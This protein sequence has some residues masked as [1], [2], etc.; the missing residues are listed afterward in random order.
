MIGRHCR[1]ARAMAQQLGAA[2]GVTILND[3]TLNQII[4]RFGAE[5]GDDASDAL[6]RQVIECFV[7]EG[8]LF[9]GGAKWRGRWVMRLSVISGQ[10]S[11]ADADRAAHAILKAWDKVRGTN[12]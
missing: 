2:P 5:Q 1:I 3:V 7:Q 12:A 9:A 10:T 6:T 4:L 8:V 11:E